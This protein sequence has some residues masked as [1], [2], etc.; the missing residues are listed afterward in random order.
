M[1][2]VHFCVWKILHSI[3][4]YPSGFFPSFDQMLQITLITLF[5]FLTSHSFYLPMQLKLAFNI[6]IQVHLSILTTD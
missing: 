4:A 6:F 2:Y 5:F 1:I 3:Q